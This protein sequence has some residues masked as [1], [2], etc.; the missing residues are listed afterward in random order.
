MSGW[1]AIPACDPI[2]PGDA[3]FEY[4]SWPMSDQTK[5]TC[6]IFVCKNSSLEFLTI[7]ILSAV[8]T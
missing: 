6:Y 3:Y 7:K 5:M 8:V 1:T 4:E 2:V